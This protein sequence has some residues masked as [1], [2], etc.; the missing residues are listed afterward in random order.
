MRATLTWPMWLR[1]LFT[2]A[3]GVAAVEFAIAV[4]IM[5]VLY[6]GSV[7]GSTLIILDRKVQNAASA[8]GDLVSRTDGTLSRSLLED[9]FQAASGIIH[10]Y[11]VGPIVQTVSGVEVM[12]SGESI[13]LWSRQYADGR[14]NSSGA[15]AVGTTLPLSKEMID[16]ASGRV[17][18]VAEASYNYA[19]S[20]AV[21]IDQAVQLNR[22][23]YHMPR[24]SQGVIVQP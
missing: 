13:V 17:V 18:I 10:P 2:N 19:P 4:P 6:L 1:R 9:Y 22:T 23:S 16:L 21:V 11:A 20:F 5:L 24:T 8:L 12:P 15:H 7:E 3:S 14:L